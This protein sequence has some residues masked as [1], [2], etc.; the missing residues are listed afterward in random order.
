MQR[1]VAMHSPSMTSMVGLWCVVFCAGCSFNDPQQQ[2]ISTARA[3]GAVVRIDI[4]GDA[5][6]LDLG[7]SRDQVRG[8]ELAARLPSLKSLVVGRDFSDQSADRLSG[9]VTLESLDL[10]YTQPGPAV[11]AVLK[12]LPHLRFLSLNGVTLTSADVAALGELRQLTSLSLVEAQLPAGALEELQ[13][14]HPQW[15]I[16]R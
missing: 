13:R 11:Y 12:G 7:P 15:L 3:L 9:L 4:R 16:A 10:S 1:D 5:A 14:A 6:G 2:A 8:L